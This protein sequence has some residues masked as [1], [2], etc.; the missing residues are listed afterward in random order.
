MDLNNLKAFVA[1][2]ETG[3]FS[4]AAERLHLT[5]PAVSKR[6][7]LLETDLKVRLF[8]RLGR[9]VLATEAGKTLLPRAQRI[10]IEVE[11]SRRALLELSQG[12][13]GVLTLATSH[14][15][16][17]HRLPP[18][19][20][21]F[22]S[23]YP[24]V[25]L[26][27]RFVDSEWGRQAVLRGEVDLAV[28]TLPPEVDPKEPPRDQGS[29]RYL[30]VWPDPL[31][32]LA[33]LDHPLVGEHPVTLEALARHPAILPGEMTYTRQIIDQ[34]FQGRGLAPKVAFATNYLE[35]IKTMVA[36]GLGWSILPR[37]LAGGDVTALTVTDF[38]LHRTLGLILHRDR[39]LSNA[40]RAMADVLSHEVATEFSPWEQFLTGVAQ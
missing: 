11:A 24:Q 9:Q 1:V 18:V 25:Q 40:A 10:L 20:R 30:P 29:L 15:I 5:Q 32:V 34:H 31:A 4:Q 28:V 35:T 2:A 33:P 14:H 17:L 7:G 22:A 8:N 38:I 36:V 16:G 23:H 37:T 12:V 39:T 26:D 3:S 19:L 27:M 13:A 6:I 21:H